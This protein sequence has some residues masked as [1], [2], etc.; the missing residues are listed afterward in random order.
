MKHLQLKALEGKLKSGGALLQDK[1]N[2]TNEKT[3]TQGLTGSQELE[4][5]KPFKA[6]AVMSVGR[7]LTKF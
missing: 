3:G 4:K 2:P 6:H 1:T 7:K 5:L